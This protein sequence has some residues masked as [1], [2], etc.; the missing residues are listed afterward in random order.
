[1]ADTT[2]GA[3]TLQGDGNSFIAENNCK[4][5]AIVSPMPLY[6]LDSDETDVFDYGGVIKTFNLTGVY[7]GTSVA[8]CKT[9]VDTC[10]GIIQGHQDRQEPKPQV[11]AQ[12]NSK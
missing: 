5:E 7:I 10:E 2:L 4:K 11:D 6:L 9:F 8:N 1:M 3:I 12:T